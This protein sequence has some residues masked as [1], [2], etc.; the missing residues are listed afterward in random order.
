MYDDL[1]DDMNFDE[2]DNPSDH[3]YQ[4]TVAMADSQ[5]QF[6][7]MTAQQRFVIAI[8]VLMMV[9]ILGAFFLLITGSFYLP[10]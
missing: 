4:A 8:M 3:D 6:L 2:E 7:G 9:C 5:T 10:L 1:R